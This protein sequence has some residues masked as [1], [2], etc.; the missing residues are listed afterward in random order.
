[1]SLQFGLTERRR[2]AGR[3]IDLRFQ[4]GW[5][6]ACIPLSL[7]LLLQGCVLPRSGP[8][9]SEVR[10]ANEQSRIVLSPITPEAV[11][12]TRSAAAASFPPSFRAAQVVDYERFGP[13]DGVDVVIWEHD[14]LGLFTPN[15]GPGLVGGGGGAAIT[16]GAGGGSSSSGANPSG[17]VAGPSAW[18][19]GGG[20]GPA[21]PSGIAGGGG[22]SS[23][24]DASDLGT[25]TIDKTGTIHLPFVGALNISGLTPEEAR[26]LLLQRLRGLVIATDVRF[27]STQQHGSLVTIQGDA[28]RAGVYSIEQG[29]QRLSDLLS[30]AAP[31]QTNPEQTAVTVRRD[32]VSATVRLMD[33]YNDASQDIAL[34]PG[35]SVVVSAIQDYVTVVGA[36]GAQGRVKI[37]KRNYSALDA[38]ADA[39]GLADS[40]A[41]PR[42]LFLIRAHVDGDKKTAAPRPTVYQ[43]DLRHPDQMLLAEQ[44]AVQDGDV[45]FVSD[46]PFTQVEKVLSSLT[47]TL[48]TARS[49]SALSQ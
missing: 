38:V 35:D 22:G 32:G 21:T 31:D 23:P 20:D 12:A 26:I 29:M 49:V 14:A 10:S 25:F 6:A 7:G 43:F 1:M 46:A 27:A 18:G 44:F 8:L 19:G 48:G 39:H 37:A 36:A 3:R 2:T 17:S 30:L 11:A 45:V 9:L 28:T 5:M 47:A 42:A 15:P 41:D 13:G 16:G 4:G 40:S 24:T 34:R 33:I